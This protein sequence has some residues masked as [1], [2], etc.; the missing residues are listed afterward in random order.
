[1]QRHGWSAKTDLGG[2]FARVLVFL[3]VRTK[4]TPV[5]DYSIPAE[6][7]I[8]VAVG[9]L[10]IVPL[11]E[12]ALPGI[13]MALTSTPAVPNTRP[14]Q[15]VLDPQPL[16]S[17]TLLDL[18]RWISRETLAPLHLC[19][20]MM[21]PPALRPHP[22]LRL[23]ALV[24]AAPSNLAKPAAQLLEALI[25]RGPLQTSQLAALLKGVDLRRARQLLQKQKLIKVERL[26]HL[27]RPQPHMT[28]MVRLDAPAAQWEEKLHGL[29]RLDLYRAVLTFLE[30]E[31]TPVQVAVVYAETG[32]RSAHLKTLSQRGLVAFSQEELLRDPLADQIFTPDSPLTLIPGQ[33]EVWDEIEPLLDPAS[34]PAPPPSR[35][36][37]PVL[38]LG[39]TGSGKTELY[40]RATAK[41]LAQGRQALILVPEIS[42]TPQTVRRF[43]ARFPGQVGLWHSGMS[44]GARLDTWRRVRNGS[45]SIVVGAR[46]ALF[47]PFPHLG[48]IVLD[49]EEDTGYKQGRMPYYHTREAAE[50]L[51]RMTGSL[52]IFGS[53]TP[54]L[55]AYARAQAGRYR[56]LQLPQRVIGHRQRLDDWQNYLH[57]DGMCYQDVEGAGS[58]ARTASLPPVQIVDMRAELKAGNR[59]VFSVALQKAV[60][61]ALARKEQTILFLNR[62]GTA[63]YIFCRDCGWVAECPH[64]EAPLTYHE[65]L[66]KL[67]CHRCGY[68]TS[69]PRLCRNCDSPRVRAFGLGTEG[70]EMRVA[71]RWPEA[72]LVRWDRDTAQSHSAHAA[73]MGRFARGDADI[74]VGTQMVARG[75]DIPKVTVVGIVSADTALNLPDFRAAERAF[76]LLAQVAG[77]SGRGLLGG[78]VLLQTYHPNHYAVQRAAEHDYTGFAKRELAFREQAGYPPAI[79][80]ARLVFAHTHRDKAQKAAESLAATLRTALQ[81]AGLPLSDLI[82][83]APAFFARV[84]GRYR[85]QILLRSVAPADF[86][87]AVEIPPGW[88]VDI[89]PL[90]VL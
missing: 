71:E 89:D 83:P 42:L 39:V 49:E 13:V 63:T 61:Q 44:E 40:M 29:H 70:L 51:A 86:L 65:G 32:A 10:V 1:M 60:D 17:A 30:A 58:N 68:K 78:R 41:V 31:R 25:R 37:V 69:M 23:T 56:L 90:D 18:A 35:A 72:Q 87:R 5:F 53:A 11:R 22:Y 77:R 82:G 16:L 50:E 34:T 15:S 74:L 88:L 79:R 21:L 54:S 57:L 47:A 67:L 27:P 75:L 52:L 2:M 36:K 80:L 6:L 55:D 26:M 64:C 81:D 48:L 43:A 73:L 33:Q 9:V 62:R 76:Q 14:I 45:V 28:Q 20:A 59:S 46:S 3:G 8:T 19:V 4:A 85:W 84:R 38:L 12:R 24:A 66:G 7:A